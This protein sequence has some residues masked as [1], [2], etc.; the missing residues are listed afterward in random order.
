MVQQL[1]AARRKLLLVTAQQHLGQILMGA[2]LAFLVCT[3]LRTRCNVQDAGIEGIM[4]KCV[5]HG[6]GMMSSVRRQRLRHDVSKYHDQQVSLMTEA[7]LI[8]HSL[9]HS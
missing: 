8:V 3:S 9:V 6:E 4:S 5:L 1:M 7:V 2:S